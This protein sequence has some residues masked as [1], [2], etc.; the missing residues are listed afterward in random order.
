MAVGKNFN[1]EI[2]FIH[3]DFSVITTEQTDGIVRP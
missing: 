2:P 3:L 1:K